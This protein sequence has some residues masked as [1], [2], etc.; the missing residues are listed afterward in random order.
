MSTFRSVARGKRAFKVY[1]VPGLDPD[2]ETPE[3][4]GFRI[5][6]A[7]ELADVIASARKFAEARGSKDPRAGDEVYDLARMA[8]TLAHCLVDSESPQDAPRPFYPRGADQVFEDEDDEV[9]SY[10]YAIW[11]QHCEAQSPRQLRQDG[12]QFLE[13]LTAMLGEDEGAAAVF[14]SRM[15]PGM[16]MQFARSLAK[17]YV[18]SLSTNSSSS[19]PSSSP[20]KSS[21]STAGPGSEATESSTTDAPAS[22]VAAEPTPS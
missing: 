3:K 2:S 16:Q 7:L 4:I 18:T 17:L 11:E 10:L 8:Y 9:I 5:M 22:T 14:F 13:G 6:G 21:S 1:E 20:E 12:A 15:R 19:T